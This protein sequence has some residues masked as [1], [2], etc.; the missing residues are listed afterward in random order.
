MATKTTTAAAAAA[1]KRAYS[2]TSISKLKVLA[3]ASVVTRAV[4]TVGN[5]TK[6]TD[7]FAGGRLERQPHRCSIDDTVPHPTIGDIDSHR[8]KGWHIDLHIEPTWFTKTHTNALNDLFTAYMTGAGCRNACE[9]AC[10]P[11]QGPYT[12]AVVSVDAPGA[13]NAGWFFRVISVALP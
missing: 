5:C 11:I 9:R 13:T 7:V 6:P 1:A 4:V 2:V 8:A 3:A 10:I 12:T